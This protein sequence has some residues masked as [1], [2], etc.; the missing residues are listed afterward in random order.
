MRKKLKVKVKHLIII[1]ILV[2][3]IL[4]N[5]LYFTG[6]VLFVWNKPIGRSEITTRVYSY[7][8][9]NLYTK[10][11]KILSP[12]EGMAY[13]SMGA[14]K[15][16]HKGKYITNGKRGISGFIPAEFGDYEDGLKL[17][18]KGLETSKGTS[19]SINTMAIFNMYMNRGNIEEAEKILENSLK[20]KNLKEN[21]AGKILR[22]Q[23]AIIEN[24]IE[25]AKNYYSEV[26]E[27][28]SIPDIERILYEAKE[29]DYYY[30]NE[31]KMIGEK[32]E[33]FNEKRLLSALGSSINV[34]Q[35]EPIYEVREN[36]DGSQTQVFLKGDSK[37][38][39][40]ITLDGV[41]M[42]NIPVIVGNVL[43]SGYYFQD[44][45]SQVWGQV[46]YTD[47]D[48]YYEAK[49][50]PS[51]DK[52]NVS[53]V[54]DVQLG[55]EYV[56]EEKDIE[57]IEKGKEY[58]LDLNFRKRMN[59]NIDKNL[60]LDGDS[61]EINFDKVEGADYYSIELMFIENS[62]GYTE[63]FE[64]KENKVKIPLLEGSL[65]PFRAPIERKRM[66]NEECEETGKEKKTLQTVMELNY[67]GRFKEN[68]I[69]AIAVR[70]IKKIGD[71]EYTLNSQR[72]ETNIR[73]KSYKVT[74]GAKLL[75]EEKYEEGE[76]WFKEKIDEEGYKKEY[77]Y[78]L[79]WLAV[80]YEYLDQNKKEFYTEER[81]LKTKKMEK[82]LLKELYKIN[83][84]KDEIA[85]FKNEFEQFYTYGYEKENLGD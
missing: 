37:V 43:Y 63:F 62:A 76:K 41:G 72:I 40:R 9:L 81:L 77:I 33:V 82:I 61:F 21:A 65:T 67:S 54:I 58:K 5:I 17:Y 8:V 7:G 53:P 29:E 85:Y 57:K 73:S 36:K 31:Q 11:P 74:Q 80:R 44:G 71:N 15:Y 25:K 2:F 78:P 46:V 1:P 30:R 14:T 26:K 69:K 27:I 84:N 13:Y 24:D 42:G 23:L 39:G 83:E 55:K 20:R 51:I 45:F 52:L 49:N 34:L 59:I 6:R 12:F 48:G 70:G 19:F 66:I 56:E 32:I 35:I 4:P 38:S 60:K 28:V 50:I 10:W 16:N 3:I 47:K 79:I 64:T 75:D 22:V 68:T 18:K